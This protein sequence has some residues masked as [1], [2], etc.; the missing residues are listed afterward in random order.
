[1]KGVYMTIV[2]KGAEYP[3]AQTL[4]VAYMVQG[5]HNHQPY[6]KVFERIGEM[7]IEEQIN[8]LYA[9]FKCANPEVVVA[10]NITSQVFLEYYLDNYNLKDV[11]EQ[12]QAVIKG[13]TGAVATEDTATG[14]SKN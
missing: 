3:L 7:T 10:Q 13:I 9:S 5:Q 12:L 11:M 4:R 14:D 6:T 8:I 2:Y 1:M